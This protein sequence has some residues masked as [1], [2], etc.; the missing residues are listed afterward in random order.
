MSVFTR[1]DNPPPPP[2]PPKSHTATTT[3]PTRLFFLKQTVDCFGQEQSAL[4][5]III[6][7]STDNDNS[8]LQFLP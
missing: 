4:E 1:Q 7:R 5:S 3:S 2:P 8:R 6:R